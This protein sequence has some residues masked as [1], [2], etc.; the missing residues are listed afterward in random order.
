MIAMI[1]LVGYLLVAIAA[2]GGVVLY[3]MYPLLT[4]YDRLETCHQCGKKT[5][6]RIVRLCQH[7]VRRIPYM[8]Y[9]C[10]SCESALVECRERI[11]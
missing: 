11:A 6:T 3:F 9:V 8:A 10:H 1:T 5:W 4:G 7:E 2:A